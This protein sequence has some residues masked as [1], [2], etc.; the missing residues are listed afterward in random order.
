M[1]LSLK[2]TSF[3]AFLKLFDCLLLTLLLRYFFYMSRMCV[4]IYV[5]VYVY[6]LIGISD[7]QHAYISI[8]LVGITFNSILEKNSNYS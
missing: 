8:K 7:W 3:V 5:C 6:N 1:A 2:H 4:Y